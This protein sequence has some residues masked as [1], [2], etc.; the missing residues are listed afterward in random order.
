MLVAAAAS[1]ASCRPHSG[2]RR[3]EGSSRNKI[4]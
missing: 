2:K 4:S 3:R 1:V